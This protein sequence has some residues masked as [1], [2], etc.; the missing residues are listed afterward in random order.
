MPDIEEH[1]RFRAELV[2]RLKAD[3]LGP[4]GARAE[5][6]EVLDDWPVTSYSTGV[7]FPRTEDEELAREDADENDYDDAS[8]TLTVDE[9]P[10]TGVNLASI[11]RPS[12]T[13]ITFAV[14]PSRSRTVRI[15]PTAAVY[16]PVDGQGNPTVPARAERR[17]VEAQDLHW[18]RRP[19]DLPAVSVDVTELHQEPKKLVP[20]LELRVRVRR[21]SG[22]RGTVSITATL[23]NTHLVGKQ[24]IR[25]THCFFQVGLRVDVPG[26]VPA[27]VERP[28]EGGVDAEVRL[29][30]L[31]HRHV[32][33]FATG[34]GCAADWNWTPPT[35]GEFPAGTGSAGVSSVWTEFVPTYEVLLTDSNPDIDVS[36]L[37]MRTLAEATPEQVTTWLG[38]LVEAYGRWIDAREANVEALRGGPYGS[39]EYLDLAREQMRLCR[40]AQ[41]RMTAGIRLL[42]RDER[43]MEAFRTANRAMALQ[44]GRGLWIKGGRQGQPEPQGVWR[45]FQI[46]FMLLCLKG[47]VDPN[48]DDRDIVDLLWFPTGGGKTEAYL[49]LIAF[50]VFHRRLRLGEAGGGVTVFMRY[51]LRLLTLQQFERAARLMCAMD[52][53]R[54][55]DPDRLGH[56]PISV[57]MWVGRAA[58]PNNLEEAKTALRKMNKG[59]TL[60][61]QNPVQLRDCPW[62]GT[63]L[64]AG[65]YTVDVDRDHMSIDCPGR[66]CDYGDGLP[67]HVVDTELYRVRP[68]LVIATV[69]KFAR[70]AWREDVAALF[71]RVTK[72]PK[73]TPPP[74]LIVQ[75]ELHLIS[76]PLGTL[77]GLYEA[78][79]DIAADRPKVIASTATIRRAMHQGR[80]LFDREVAQF[81]PAGLDARDSWFAVQAS[82]ERKASRRYV[83]LL[84]PGISQAT[85]L[86]RAYASLLHHASRI[87]GDDAVRDAYWTLVGYFNSLRLLAA[88]ELQVHADVNERL[89]NHARRDGDVAP[90]EVVPKELTSRVPSSEIPD[91]LG[92]LGRTLASGAAVDVVLA[93]NMISV[94]VDIDRLGLMAVLGQPQTTAEYIQATSRVGRQHPG[95]VVTLFN[96]ARS[97]DLSHYEDFVPYHSALY[98]QVESTSVTP[99]SARARDRALH[100]VFVGLARLMLPIARP[101]KAA[102]N[103]HAFERDLHDL[104]TALVTRVRGIEKEEADATDAELEAFIDDWNRLAEENGGL[105]YEAPYSYSP[106]PDRHPDTALLRTHADLDLEEAYPTLWSLRDV[107]VESDLYLES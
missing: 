88:A 81:P 39:T 33:A 13:G 51:T 8:S 96:S 27:L 75:D 69:D 40:V 54:A 72:A 73:G 78:A 25:D 38:D 52:R 32:P 23:V 84:A 4:T 67:V 42:E 86:I 22:P 68:T 100:A 35:V 14:D 47:I 58:T 64:R 77:T 28:T 102:A 97:R 36:R 106:N 20:G 101:N 76:G 65:D 34:H 3:L 74:E 103:V 93:T 2:D 91:R 105:L 107:D 46:G 18:R 89:K 98:K 80:A 55:E 94:G 92:E 12:A 48:H 66:G 62:C 60:Q 57:G 71:N 9:V 83:G 45:P 29:N 11:Q 90:R 10:D 37:G 41:K 21:P 61:E 49:G 31:L 26:E 79:V 24:D 19:L 63:A 104:R 44:L 70:V 53:V 7:L 15:T 17:A 6:A 50:T 5:S 59:E 43:A 85:L 30:R 99:Y 95:L 56:E 1:Y 87:D 82:A 16:D